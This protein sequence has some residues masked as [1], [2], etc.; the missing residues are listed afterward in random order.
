MGV[1]GGMMLGNLLGGLA[2]QVDNS[3]QVGDWVKVDADTGVIEV[4]KK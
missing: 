2:I 3:V 4:T 1:A